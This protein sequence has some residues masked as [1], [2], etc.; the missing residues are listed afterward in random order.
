MP[1]GRRTRDPHSVLHFA[2]NCF[3]GQRPG[4]MPAQGKRGTSAA[5]GIG[6]NRIKALKGRDNVGPPL[7][8]F[9]HVV[10]MFQGVAL[11]WHVSGLL[12]LDA[13]AVAAAARRLFAPHH[14]AAFAHPAARGCKPRLLC[15][16]RPHWC[17]RV[18]ALRVSPDLSRPARCD[19]ATRS[20]PIFRH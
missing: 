20:P 7:Q 2:A 1:D 16:R 4:H 19:G 11:G 3:Q 6:Q 10:R 18:D 8:G 5:L 14:P 9:V 15:R 13:T 17:F 12:A